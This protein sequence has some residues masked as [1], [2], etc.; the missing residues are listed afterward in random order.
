MSFGIWLGTEKGWRFDVFMRASAAAAG[1][2]YS[3]I[4]LP[5][6]AN[7]VLLTTT[8]FYEND[9]FI[10]DVRYGD[11]LPEE[12]AKTI[13]EYKL[14]KADIGIVGMDILSVSLYEDLKKELYTARFFH[15]DDIIMSLRA[16]KSPY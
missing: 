15:S 11:D 6:D 4:V 3:V 13:K 1:R 2:G 14:E 5:I 8:P 16:S 10:K 9:L 12:I 7:P